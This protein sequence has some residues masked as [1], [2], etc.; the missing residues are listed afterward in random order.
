MNYLILQ[1]KQLKPLS[2]N[3]LPNIAKLKK[4]NPLNKI[5]Q[6]CVKV[7]QRTFPLQL[8]FIV[9]KKKSFKTSI[10]NIIHDFQGRM[11]ENEDTLEAGRPICKLLKEHKL[12]KDVGNIDLRN[13]QEIELKSLGDHQYKTD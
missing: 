1:I 8:L 9:K 3:G 4:K 12:S 2:D 11:A 7:P 5:Y 13:I 6:K 10:L